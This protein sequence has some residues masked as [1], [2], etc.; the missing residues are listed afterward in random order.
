MRNGATVSTLEF[1]SNEEN[2]DSSWDPGDDVLLSSTVSSTD[3]ASRSYSW[4]GDDTTV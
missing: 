3:Q 1:D 2:R 4:S